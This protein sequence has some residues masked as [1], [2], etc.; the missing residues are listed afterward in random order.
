MEIKKSRSLWTMPS[1]IIALWMLILTSCGAQLSILPI[2]QPTAPDNDQSVQRGPESLEPPISNQPAAKLG[3]CSTLDFRSILWP[4]FFS[5]IT[6]N[7]FALALNVTSSFEGRQSWSALAGDSDQMG[8]SLGLIQQN[9]GSGTL[10]PLLHK[11]RSQ[12]NLRMKSYF[13]REHWGLIN[14]MLDGWLQ[15]LSPQSNLSL[16]TLQELSILQGL[17][18]TEG[19]L[20]PP[21]SKPLSDLDEAVNGQLVPLAIASNDEVLWAR[22]NILS[23]Q[24]VKSDWKAEFQAMAAS[25][26]Y[27]NIQFKEAMKL[28]LK[29]EKYRDFFGFLSLQSYLFLFDVV[30]QNGGFNESHLAKFNSYLKNTPNATELAKLRKLLEIRLVSVRPQYV[31]DVTARKMTILTGQGSVHGQNRNLNKEYCFEKMINL[32]PVQPFDRSFLQ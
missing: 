30:V 22:R 2:N 3:I 14:E 29:T 27:K 4:S 6:K 12:F 18:S 21:S 26:E 24:T 15:R 20:F 32:G 19:P 16:Q 9:L 5:D 13:S 17:E 23:G 11:N 1:L 10:Q 8:L 25:S 7:S 31:Q 28:H